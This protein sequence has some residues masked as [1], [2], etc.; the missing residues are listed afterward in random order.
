VLDIPNVD[1]HIIGK[2]EVQLL[3]CALIPPHHLPLKLDECP[4]AMFWH[5]LKKRNLL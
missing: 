1:Q 4:D 2:D 5:S 3:I